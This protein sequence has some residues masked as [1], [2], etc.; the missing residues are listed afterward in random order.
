MTRNQGYSR[1]S[2]CSI[3]LFARLNAP[4]SKTKPSFNN[5]NGEPSRH[6]HHQASHKRPVRNGPGEPA[7]IDPHGSAL[8]EL[9]QQ[10]MSADVDDR[11]VDDRRA[12]QVPRGHGAVPIGPMEENRATYWQQELS[13]GD[14]PRAEHVDIALVQGSL[15]AVRPSTASTNANFAFDGDTTPEIAAKDQ[16]PELLLELEVVALEPLPLFQ[17][18]ETSEPVAEEAPI[19]NLLLLDELQHLLVPVCDGGAN[20]ADIEHFDCDELIEVLLDPAINWDTLVRTKAMTPREIPQRPAIKLRGSCNTVATFL[21]LL[22]LVFALDVLLTGG[23]KTLLPLLSF[24]EAYP[25]RFLAFYRPK[26]EVLAAM[27]SDLIERLDISEQLSDAWDF[28]AAMVTLV[29]VHQ[30]IES[31]RTKIASKLRAS[32]ETRAE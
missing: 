25:T 5:I 32:T 15:E 18:C 2:S 22:G 29:C 8:F 4:R 28:T 27:A 19:A 13:S 7:P 9:Q 3:P 6:D 14:D 16:P 1:L 21:R 20:Y 17:N 31:A 11:V 24:M 12:Q 26:V 30:V 23:S 10:Q